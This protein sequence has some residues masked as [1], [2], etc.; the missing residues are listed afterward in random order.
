MLSAQKLPV[1]F[2]WCRHCAGM[3]FPKAS[4][5]LRRH[6]TLPDESWGPRRAETTPERNCPGCGTLMRVE[7]DRE[8][9]LDVCDAC[10]GVWLDPGEY[11]SALR[12]AAKL[13]MKRAVPSLAPDPPG[14]AKRVL[15]RLVDLVGEYYIAA[16]R[17]EETLFEF[18]QRT[19]KRPRR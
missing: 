13:R 8:I 9:A 19:G 14:F 11:P 12:R 15:D 16:H 2:W 6:A 10:G 1:P 5:E 4:L 7:S 3:W 17:K 18:L